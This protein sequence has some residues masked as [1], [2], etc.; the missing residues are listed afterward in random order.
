V[1]A[2]RQAAKAADREIAGRALF[3]S[4]KA[5]VEELDDLVWETM[6]EGS[7]MDPRSKEFFRDEVSVAVEAL[8]R[9]GRLM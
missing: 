8:W 1:T 2:E 9:A 7:F 3:E 5:G 6:P 4:Y